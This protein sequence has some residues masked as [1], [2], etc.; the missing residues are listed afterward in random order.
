M[1]QLF[2]YHG[3]LYVVLRDMPTHQFEDKKQVVDN[4]KIKVWKRWLEADHV[5][6][7]NDRYLFV[8][9]VPEIEFQEIK[10]EEENETS[11]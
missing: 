6:K 5:L 7:V 10:L 2:H 8:E 11:N 9:V 1:K 4:T 3:T